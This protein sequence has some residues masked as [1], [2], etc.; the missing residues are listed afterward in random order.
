MPPT[1]ETRVWLLRHGASTFNLQHRCQGCSDEPELTAQ[2]RK[3]SLL[4][5]ER[6][7]SEGIQAVIASPLRRAADTADELMKVLCAQDYAI[8]LE[9]DARLRE[10]ELYNWEGLPLKEIRH[11]FPEQYCKWRLLP[12]SFQMRLTDNELRFP[13]RD[14]YDRS[15]SF[16]DYLPTA[17]SGKSILLVTHGGTIRALIA[18]ALDLRPEHFQSFQQSNCGLTL[19]RFP[20]G[21]RRANLDLHNDTTHL[22]ERLPKLKEGRRGTRLLFIPVIEECLAPIH[23]LVAA[24]EGIVIEHAVTI[25]STAHELASR[26]FSSTGASCV[27]VSEGTANNAVDQLPQQY[28]GDQLRHA[29]ILGPPEILRRIVQQQLRISDPAAGSLDFRPLGIT[30]VHRPAKEVPAVLQSLNTSKPSPALVGG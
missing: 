27:V 23:D 6:L 10:I 4:S 24:L 30:A 8:T 29:A 13:V 21:S 16:W 22:G 28:S 19:L 18:T 25:G 9:T 2:G 14:L 11:R 12:D 1:A 17:H 5:A 20:F 7:V 15:K 3:Q 26:L